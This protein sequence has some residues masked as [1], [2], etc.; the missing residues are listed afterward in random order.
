MRDQC[1]TWVTPGAHYQYPDPAPDQT[2]PEM[3][4]PLT[5]RVDLPTVQLYA[6]PEVY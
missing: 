6:R 2:G 1:W 4:Y 3:Y 5:W